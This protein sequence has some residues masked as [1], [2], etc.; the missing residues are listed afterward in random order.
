MSDAI[1]VERLTKHYGPKRVVNQVSLRVPTGCVYGFLGRNG[2]GKSTLIKMLM[3]MVRPDAGASS[4]LGRP[5]ASLDP[6]TRARIAYLA[7]G[8]PIYR[9]MSVA[10]ATQFTRSFYPVW[11]Q[12]FLEE[13]L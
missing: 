6:A 5:S 12:R 10:Q 7:E 4:L 3:N 1:I 8:H 13:I 2:A 9:W 11:H